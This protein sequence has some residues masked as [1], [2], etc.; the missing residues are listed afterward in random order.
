VPNSP[1]IEG[2][3]TRLAPEADDAGI[4]DVAYRTLDKPAGPVL[5]NVTGVAGLVTATGVDW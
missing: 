3:H 1:L 5:V 2:L 4:L